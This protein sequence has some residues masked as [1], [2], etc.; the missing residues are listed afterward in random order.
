MARNE[1]GTGAGSM[2]IDIKLDGSNY[3]EWAFSART[4]VRAAGL[5]S[6]LTD[7]PPTRDDEAAKKSWQK[8]DDRVMGAL[9]LGVDPSLRMSLEH[10]TS[11][12]EIWKYFEQRYLQPSGALHFSLL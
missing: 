5:V 7:D 11:A 9:V 6:H 3:R 4:V 1:F 2:S 8:A 10:H 12:K